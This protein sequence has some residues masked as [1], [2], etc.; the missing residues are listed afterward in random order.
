[1]KKILIILLSLILFISIHGQEKAGIS[2]G[3][4]RVTGGRVWYRVVGTESGIPLLLVHGGPGY[5]SH[6]LEPLS[7]L[8]DERPVIFYDQL[9]CGRSDRPDD[10]SLWK[11]E[12]FVDE[13]ARVRKALNL[14]KVHIL[15]HSW[16]ASLA[17]DYML[18]N[19]SPRGVESLILASP[20]LSASR[21]LKDVEKHRAALPEDLQEILIKHE[22]SGTF[23]S[24]EYNKAVSVYYRRHVCRLKGPDKNIRAATRG[25]NGKI[26]ELLWGPHEFYGTGPLKDYER[27]DRLHEI[28]VPTLFTCGR[29]EGVT[30]EAA[31]WFQSLVKGA[32]LAVFE[33][34]AHMAINEEPRR[35]TR[36]LRDFLKN[37]EKKSK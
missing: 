2:E 10:T 9:G 27:T 23:N 25:S 30:P 31:A 13:L 34:S 22:K 32:K 37:V 33:E 3:Y 12:R 18:T 19:P 17:V 5:P 15:G 14:K 24:R 4:I 20:F 16:G 29:Y 28:K 21:Y 36:E 6:Y 11:I 1:M 8:S 35:F 26:Y 7:G